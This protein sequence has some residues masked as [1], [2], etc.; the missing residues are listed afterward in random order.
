MLDTGTTVSDLHVQ[1]RIFQ[2]LNDISFTRRFGSLQ[3]AYSSPGTSFART[4][5]GP[6][7]GRQCQAQSLRSLCNNLLLHLSLPLPLHL[8]RVYS[9]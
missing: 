4:F 2:L 9:K 7:S 3:L 6:L 8:A 5:I 1:H